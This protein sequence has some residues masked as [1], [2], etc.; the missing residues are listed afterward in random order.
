M[1][2]IYSDYVMYD[3]LLFMHYPCAWLTYS[4]P[5]RHTDTHTDT[6]TQ[7][8]T[9]TDPPTPHTHTHIHFNRRGVPLVRAS[10]S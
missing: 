5:H 2:L 3:M 4:H 10:A 6:Q 8:H 9:D 7:T 1:D